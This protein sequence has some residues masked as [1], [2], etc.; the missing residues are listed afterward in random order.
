MWTHTSQTNKPSKDV[1]L[2][3]F[4][5]PYHKYLREC[6]KRKDSFWLVISEVSVHGQWF[7]LFEPMVSKSIMVEETWWRELLTSW[8]LG[9]RRENGSGTRCILWKYFRPWTHVQLNTSTLHNGDDVYS[10]HIWPSQSRMFCI[11]W[12]GHSPVT[13][14]LQ[15]NSTFFLSLNNVKILGPLSN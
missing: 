9:S 5:Y 2:V 8:Q 12:Q 6:Q 13:Y 14:F 10:F 15:V 3:K 11:M 1:G 4:F 7:H